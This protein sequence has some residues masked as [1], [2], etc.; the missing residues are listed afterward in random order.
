MALY[1]A[2]LAFLVVLFG[3]PFILLLLPDDDG[4]VGG[5]PAV[6]VSATLDMKA[7]MEEGYRF[8][9]PSHTFVM[10]PVKFMTELKSRPESEVSAIEEIADRFLGHYTT[11]GKHQPVFLRAMRTDV[12]K[13]A[14]RS[15]QVL[16]QECSAAVPAE[17]GDAVKRTAVLV[18]SFSNRVVSKMIGTMVAGRELGHDEVWLQLA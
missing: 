13:M 15:I 16:L 18:Q 3:A 4:Q 10:L 9:H 1:W 5:L 7:A 6:R 8:K 17:I 14:N 11:I 2:F 12:V